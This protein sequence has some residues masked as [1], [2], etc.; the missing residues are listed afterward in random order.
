MQILK[1]NVN[2]QLKEE[3]ERHLT[4]NEKYNRAKSSI[5]QICFCKKEKEKQLQNEKDNLEAKLKELE[6]KDF[7]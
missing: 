5:N 2:G 1:G 3:K 7:Q 4:S 6:K